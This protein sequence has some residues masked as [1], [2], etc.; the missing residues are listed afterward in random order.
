MSGLADTCPEEVGTRKAPS[1]SGKFQQK[2]NL[3]ESSPF[4]KLL[5][6][7]TLRPENMIELSYSKTIFSRNA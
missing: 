4:P 1:R 5:L 7:L 3:R 2:E 6:R